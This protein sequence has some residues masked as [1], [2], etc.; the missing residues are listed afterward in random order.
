MIPPTTPGSRAGEQPRRS[1]GSTTRPAGL[2]SGPGHIVV[3][4]NAA[5]VSAFGGQSVGLPAREGMLGL[6]AEAFGLLDVGPSGGTAARP[7]DHPRGPAVAADRDAEIRIRDDRA[8]RRRVPPPG[9]LRPARP[10]AGMSAADELI[11]R[12]RTRAADPERRVDVRPSQFMAGVSTLD[13]SGL[14]GMLGS[15]SGDLRRVVAANQAGTP[16]DPALHAKAFAKST[17]EFAPSVEAWLDT[18][19]GAR[20]GPVQLPTA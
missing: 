17:T 1:S 20:C 12:L 13:L 5:F 18:W 2:C 19:V 10:A 4:G 16:V 6:P 9:P 14:M 15:V 7:L 8:V 3:Y 11:A